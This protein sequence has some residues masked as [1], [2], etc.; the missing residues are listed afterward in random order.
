M[1]ESINKLLW[2]FAAI[3]I[4]T[5]GFVFT[6]KFGGVQFHFKRMFSSLFQKNNNG[7]I[8][9]FG[10][11]MMVMA[12]RIGVGSLAGVALAIYYGGPGAIFWMWIITLLCAVHT[13]A[14]TVLGNIY[15]EKDFKKI[16]KG[17]PMYYIKNGLHKPKLGL[18]YAI[19]ILIA[20]VGG[21]IGIQ[22]N[23]IT[24]SLNI[25]YLLSPIIVGLILVF[26][27][28]IIIFG[29]VERISNITNKLVP[30]MTLFYV[31]ISFFIIIMSWNHI[32]QVFGSIFSDAFNMKSFIGG[33]IPMVMI[34]IQRGIFA[35][36]AG[37]GTGSI[38]S[39]ITNS[40]D[41]ISLGYIQVIGIYITM[42]LICTSTALVIL[43]SNYLTLDF[44]DMN[45][46]ELTQ[47]AFTN[48]LGNFGN[49]FVFISILLFSFSTI[50]TGYYYGESSL[51][52]IKKNVNS[53]HLTIL[54]V[55]T[56]IILFLGAIMS[57]TLLWKIV[58][59]MVAI[60]AIVNVYAL[61][62]LKDDVKSEIIYDKKVKCDKMNLR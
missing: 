41:S 60:L 22:A 4:V 33:F 13:F 2:G 11:L 29:G 55:I 30:C 20:Y 9:A 50:L 45:G 40:D 14:E 44:A 37:L 62:E 39:S 49:Y 6:K 38:A 27:T 28:A 36:E 43:N 61:Y 54:K 58:D 16:Y 57:S 46:I 12:G 59:I 3:M 26:L 34:G 17:G 7:G 56:L 32:P 1:L 52:Y 18:L 24:K 42:F 21:F 5:G 51:K 35:M 23:T 47:H 48:F 25:I 10:T 15:K 19:F 53:F 31:G 8:S